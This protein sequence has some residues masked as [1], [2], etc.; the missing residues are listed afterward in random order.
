MFSKITSSKGMG[1]QQPLL[2]RQR[3]VEGSRSKERGE[4]GGE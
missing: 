2:E 4:C 1:G 3:D